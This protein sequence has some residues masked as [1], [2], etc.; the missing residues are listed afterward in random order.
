[1]NEA[2]SPDT[3]VFIGP[4]LVAFEQMA[5]V[6]Q[7]KGLRTHWIGF[8][9][10]AV[11]RLRTRIFTPVSSANGTD[12][13]R[14]ELEAIGPARILDIQASEFVM[15]EVLEAS[16]QV[17]GLSEGLRQ[18]LQRRGQWLDKQYTMDRLAEAGV[19]VP[20]QSTRG[21]SAEE[22]VAELG[23]PVMVKGR[24]GN[25]GASVRKCDDAAQVTAAL[26][27]LAKDGGTYAEEFCTGT[28]GLC[29]FA[30]YRED[31]SI[32][33]DGAYQGLRSAA[34]EAELGELGPLDEL[35]TLANEDLLAA[36]RSVVAQL[37]GRGVVNVDLIRQEDG[38]L[39]VLDVN[40]RPWGAIVA[41]RT[42]GIDMVDAYLAAT[43]GLPHDRV[44]VAPGQKVEV[45]ST[46]A[47]NAAF[48]SPMRGVTVF[49]RTA[50]RHQ[51]WTG[52]RYLVAEGIR[53]S[54][55]VARHWLLKGLARRRKSTDSLQTS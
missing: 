2:A 52:G 21:A 48:A 7:R 55:V 35:V 24:V 43:R 29:Y 38:S 28:D 49:T 8:P 54:A 11:R 18:E 46:T 30:A 41:L 50:R 10:S 20:R 19:R 26:Q 15:P 31:G 16:R 37:G 53:A 22:I 14:R 36:G 34:A 17:T 45:F 5:A 9:Y 25:G 6:L 32:L 1:M 23:L 42:A 4:G 47:I 27:E 40:Q 13:L 44:Q 12:E 33:A 51:P 3:I 39:V